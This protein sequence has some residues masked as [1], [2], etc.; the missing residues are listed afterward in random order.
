MSKSGERKRYPQYD[1]V[2]LMVC[3][4]IT[5]RFLNVICLFNGFIPLIAIQMKALKVGDQITIF[6]TK[7]LDQ[8]VGLATEEEDII[9][10]TD[11][12]YW[13]KRGAKVTFAMVDDRIVILR[14]IDPELELKYNKIFYRTG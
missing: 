10:I 6:F 14:Q 8:R 5:G 13:E 12:A 7:V 4:E 2:A 11:R 9:E 3:E 1:H